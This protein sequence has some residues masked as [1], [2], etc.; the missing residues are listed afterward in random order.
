MPPYSVLPVNERHPILNINSGQG[1][2]TVEPPYTALPVHNKH[3]SNKHSGEVQ[4]YPFVTPSFT[5]LPVY[6]KY[7]EPNVN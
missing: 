5:L 4:V 3:P 7:L 2:P 6:D 1:V